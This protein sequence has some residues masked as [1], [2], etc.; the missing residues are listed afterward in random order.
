MMINAMYGLLQAPEE[1]A[2][3][4]VDCLTT[5]LPVF[6]SMQDV[7][8]MKILQALIGTYV[9]HVLANVTE[10]IIMTSVQESP[11]CRLVSLKYIEALLSSSDVESRWMLCNAYGD[12]REDIRKEA[13]RLLQLSLSVSSTV[14]SFAVVVGLFAD[15]LFSQGRAK[16]TNDTWHIV[17]FRS[18]AFLHVANARFSVRDMRLRALPYR[19]T[20]RPSWI[21]QPTKHIWNGWLQLGSCCRVYV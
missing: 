18:Y 7:A 12:S 21:W 20:D 10:E 3:A 6:S 15:K 13:L 5:W 8:A 4:I 17:S 14:P 19:R 9:A 2:S 1:V 11:K 16:I